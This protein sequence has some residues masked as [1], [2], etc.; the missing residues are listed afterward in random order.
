MFLT[1]RSAGAGGSRPRGAHPWYAA[2][3][4]LVLATPLSAQTT[5]GG[6]LSLVQ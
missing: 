5:Y 4:A 1:I 2:L 3:C 6:T